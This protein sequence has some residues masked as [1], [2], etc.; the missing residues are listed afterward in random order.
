MVNK[1]IYS[2]IILILI[3]TGCVSSAKGRVNT[4]RQSI[5][6]DAKK[7]IGTPYKYGG[8]SAKGFDCSGFT[9]FIYKRNGIDIPRTVT[10]MEKSFK[11]TKNPSIGDIVTFNNPNHVGILVGNNKFI[12][13][14]TSRGVVIDN[15]SDSWYKKRLNGYFTAFY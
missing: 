7:Y 10:E 6:N 12:H 5:V 3:L 11:K 8:T 4:V 1:R 2:V 14:S 13:A 9:Q 15:L